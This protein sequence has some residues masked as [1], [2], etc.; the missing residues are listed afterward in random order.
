M[1]SNC[2]FLGPGETQAPGDVLLNDPVIHNPCS[3]SHNSVI[4]ADILMLQ[5]DPAFGEI[6]WSPDTQLIPLHHSAN[7]VNIFYKGI[8]FLISL[9]LEPDSQRQI[10]VNI[11]QKN[12]Q[13]LNMILKRTNGWPVNHLMMVFMLRG[14]VTVIESI[15]WEPGT[16]IGKLLLTLSQAVSPGSGGYLH[17][18]TQRDGF[19]AW[20][21]A[22]KSRVEQED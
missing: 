22:I 18:S 6:F 21:I 20:L 3:L 1:F 19:P 16:P 13:R 8:I 11:C 2:R 15:H 4:I 5:H 17:G 9:W 10:K 7:N 12:N 14:T